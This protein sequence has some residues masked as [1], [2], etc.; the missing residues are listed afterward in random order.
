MLADTSGLLVESAVTGTGI[1]KGLSLARGL[2]SRGFKL[3]SK[4]I[5]AGEEAA[6]LSG[7]KPFD[8]KTWT[9]ATLAIRKGNKVIPAVL[10]GVKELGVSTAAVLPLSLE[11]AAENRVDTIGNLLNNGLAPGLSTGEET[12]M[13]TAA[14]I[15]D[16]GTAMLP[17]IPTLPK[18]LRGSATEV[19]AARVYN[20]IKTKWPEIKMVLLNQVLKLLVIS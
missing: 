13:L 5:Y 10:K 7:F 12:L 15:N 11:E 19:A 6:V 9:P 16:V 1:G 8:P 18:A 14:W 4:A 2:F 20:N 3:G 17:K